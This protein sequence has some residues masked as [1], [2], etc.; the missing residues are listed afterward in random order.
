[1]VA[2]QSYL[3]KIGIKMEIVKLDRAAF[4]STIR[5][6]STLEKNG[7]GFGVMEVRGGNNL[8]MVQTYLVSSTP[9]YKYMVK[10]A[11]I[12]DMTAQAI[13]ARDDQAKAKLTQ[14]IVKA[15]YDDAC[16]IPVYIQPR[17]LIMDKR[18]QDIGFFIGGDA[19]NSKLGR[20]TWLK[21]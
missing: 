3:S 5:M 15:Y 19:D 9:Y 13:A 18:T 7:A 2:A 11:G 4:T 17:S 8:F 10:P 20:I 16:F 14:Q 6:G 21:Q 12:D 1:M